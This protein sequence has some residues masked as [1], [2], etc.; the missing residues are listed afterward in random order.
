MATLHCLLAL[1]SSKV[2]GLPSPGAHDVPA[3]C[4]RFLQ[5]PL[6]VQTLSAQS[7]ALVSHD[8][9]VAGSVPHPVAGSQVLRLQVGGVPQFCAVPPVVSHA[10]LEQMPFVQLLPEFA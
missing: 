10:P 7:L 2:H 8:V 4:A 6:S 5:L 3:G 1:H 9:P